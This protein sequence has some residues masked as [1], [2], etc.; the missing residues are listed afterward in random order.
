[1]YIK[2]KLL[3]AACMT[4]LMFWAANAF[5]QESSITPPPNPP[6][7]WQQNPGSEKEKQNFMLFVKDIKDLTQED[8]AAIKAIFDKRKADFDA[9][10]QNTKPE[11]MDSEVTKKIA[12]IN[13][14]FFESIRTYVKADKLAD[15]DKYV[16]EILSKVGNPPMQWWQGP[17]MSQG[18]GP[19]VLFQFFK[20]GKSLT[21]EQKKA[22]V[23]LSKAYGDSIK[24]IVED[25]TKTQE[26]KAADIKAANEYFVSKITDYVDP[27]KLDAF[28]KFV[29]ERGST[30]LFPKP[31]DKDQDLWSMGK[32]IADKIKEKVWEK[33]KEIQKKV[34]KLSQKLRESF[35]KALDKISSE[36]KAETFKLVLSRIDTILAKSETNQAMK[37]KLTELKAIVQTKLDELNWSSQDTDLINSLINWTTTTWTWTAQ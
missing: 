31:Q 23:D 21:E 27:A 9:L 17:W 37:D 36:K 8:Q 22:F 28:N 14:A 7:A 30:P 25:T 19:W 24:K 29:A 33:V 35:A 1:M 18:A 15:F 4:S 32:D 3:A 6:A 12:E 5:A 10:I 13:K 11:K 2:N 16:K 34:F 20:D 26:Q